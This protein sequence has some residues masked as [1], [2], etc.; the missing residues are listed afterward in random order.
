MKPALF[1]VLCE[2]KEKTGKSMR[3]EP[4]GN[5]CVLRKIQLSHQ[6][7][8]HRHLYNSSSF[9]FSPL[10]FLSVAAVFQSHAAQ[11]S[12]TSPI[13]VRLKKTLICTEL[14]YFVLQDEPRRKRALTSAW[15]IAGAGWMVKHPLYLHHVTLMLPYFHLKRKDRKPLGWNTT[16]GSVGLCVWSSVHMPTAGIYLQPVCLITITSG[17]RRTQC[18]SKGGL[19]GGFVFFFL[20]SIVCPVYGIIIDTTGDCL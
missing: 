9:G 20:N 8:T 11:P 18:A 1:S 2:I 15:F 14:Q 13:L 4:K 10:S 7:L 3:V 12:T 5:S 16:V 19:E 17:V 6:T